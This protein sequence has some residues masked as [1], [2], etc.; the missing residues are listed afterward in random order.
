MN[1]QQPDPA[2]LFEQFQGQA[3]SDPANRSVTGQL[4]H[5]PVPDQS[6]PRVTTIPDSPP[7]PS[8]PVNNDPVS[9]LVALSQSGAIKQLRALK[10]QQAKVADPVNQLVTM[11]QN[12]SLTAMRLNWEDEQY[13]QALDSWEKQKKEF[14]PYPGMGINAY[15]EAPGAPTRKPEKIAQDW[16]K[17]VHYLRGS[18]LGSILNQLETG[19]LTPE[20]EAQI[21]QHIEPQLTPEIRTQ[22]QIARLTRDELQKLNESA[23]VEEQVA[24]EFGRDSL[25]K[26]PF[27]IAEDE[28][29]G[30]NARRG[31]V[32]GRNL[33]KGLTLGYSFAP[34]EERLKSDDP[35]I[36]A[37]ERAKRLFYLQQDS[38]YPVTAFAGN[39]VGAMPHFMAGGALIRGAR[40]GKALLSARAGVPTR[41]VANVIRARG[42]ATTTGGSVAMGAG[43]GAIYD[44][45]TRPEGSEDMSLAEE[46]QARATQVGFGVA[47][48][49]MMELGLLKTG[50]LWQ[51]AKDKR[52]ESQLKKEAKAQGYGGDVN[53][54]LNDLLVMERTDDGR[55]LARPRRKAVSDLPDVELTNEYPGTAQSQR[56]DNASGTKIDGRT[57]PFTEFT[58]TIPERV[59][60]T[61]ETPE[62][63]I[64]VDD[65]TLT[66]GPQS[67]E[68]SGTSK[69][70][71]IIQGSEQPA[72][73][74]QAV[75]TDRATTLKGTTVDVEYELVDADDL[76]TSHL[77]N[78]VVNPDFPAEL[79]PRDRSR[80]ASEAQI[81]SMAADLRPDWLGRSPKASDG[82][83]IIGEDNLVES[84]NGRVSA[85]RQAYA[86]GSGANYRQW[87][88]ENAGQFGLD[89]SLVD[90]MKQPVLVRRRKTAMDNQ[91]RAAFT[92]EANDSDVAR[93]SPSEQARTDASRLDD[94]DIMMFAPDEGG[95]IDTNSNVPFLRRFM[96]RVG[97]TDASAILDSRGRPNQAFV[98][99]V[100]S[101]VFKRAYDDDRLLSLMAETSESELRGESARNILSALTRAAP[102]FARARAM[103]SI[104]AESD[105]IPNMLE[106]VDLVRQSRRDN[107]S[108]SEIISQGSLLE[109]VDPVTEELARFF[110]SNLRSSHRMGEVLKDLGQQLENE[111]A[112]G[113][114]DLFGSAPA[115]KSDFMAATNRNMEARGE[116]A[117]FY[118][119][120]QEPEI[121]EVPGAAESRR[122]EGESAGVGRTETGDAGNGETFETLVENDSHSSVNSE[123]ESKGNTFNIDVETP[124][125][126][127]KIS[128]TKNDDGTITAD[129]QP[130]PK[131]GEYVP[132]THKG[133]ST[134]QANS[135]G[136]LY[137]N[138]INFAIRELS[139]SMN[140]GQAAASSF[141]GGVYGGIQSQQSGEEIGSEQWWLDV[142]KGASAATLGFAA[143]RYNKVIGKDSI[144]SKFSK[145]LG[146]QW[147]KIP[148][149][150][151]GSPEIRRLK[152]QQ[153]LMRQIINRQTGQMGEFLAKNFTP[154]ERSEMADIIENRGYPKHANLVARQAQELDDFITYTADRMKELGMLPPDMET[155]GYLHRYY[156]KHLKLGLDGNL[157]DAFKRAK[158]SLSGSYTIR[159]G[160]NETF[161]PEYLS[162]AVR[163]QMAEYDRI[164]DRISEL[165]GTR[166]DI[167]FD[168]T[169]DELN[170]LRDQLK[171]LQDIQLKEY[172]GIQNGKPHAFIFMPDEVPKVPGLEPS[173]GSNTAPVQPEASDRIWSLR[174]SVGDQPVLWRD[175][176]KAEREKWGEIT[177]AGYRFVRGQAEIAHD[178]SMATMFHKISQRSD[179]VSNRPV[180]MDGEDWIEVPNSKIHK[181]SPMKTYGALAGKYVKPD[182]WRSLKHYNQPLFGRGRAATIYRNLLDRWKLY[183]TVYNPV[184]HFN[185]TVS[186]LQMYYMAGYSAR[187]IV[188]AIN[189]LLK[190]E[191]S[192]LWREARDV[193]MF[194]SDWTSSLLE[195]GEQANSLAELAEVLRNQPDFPDANQVN[196]SVILVNRFKTWL[197]ES[198]AS[199]RNAD[200]KLGS[201]AAVAKAIASPVIDVMNKPI[202]A[203][204]DGAKWLYQKE[205]ELYKMAVFIE[206][207]KKGRSPYEALEAANQFFF[208][209]SDLPDAVR[210][211]K[212]F[213][214]GSP[215]IS[216]TYLALPAI[217][218]NI[219]ER[220]ERVL[221]LAAAFEGLNFASLA[222]DGQLE[223]QGYWDRYEA[224]NIL[225]PSYMKGRTLWGGLNSI[226]VSGFLP[227]LD[228]YKISLANAHAMGSP[229]TGESGR[230]LPLWPSF[231]GFWGPDPIGG[232]PV[233]R[234]PFDILF[235]LDWQGNQLY[236]ENNKWEKSLK[237]AYQAMFPSMPLFPFSWH[238]NKIVEG[239]AGDLNKAQEEGRPANH[240]AEGIVTAANSVSEALGGEQFTGADWKGNQFKTIDALA[241]SVGI[242][243]RQYKP[244]DLY[245]IQNNKIKNKMDEDRRAHKRKMRGDYTK[246]QK[247]KYKEEY[248]TRTDAYK[249]EMEKL[250]EAYNSIA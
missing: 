39:I 37:D 197:I 233:T 132:N 11:S 222:L 178:L 44:A 69:A 4:T 161:K 56:N 226:D 26:N 214:I 189:E 234:I 182:V 154:A 163:G 242:K 250:K 110:D 231:M 121:T 81:R 213:P 140:L 55:L 49:S 50:D 7:T 199:V 143:L 91:Q 232:N 52:F 38:K 172:V 16:Q 104:P 88:K 6:L 105:F 72:V 21:T 171:E 177:D 148:G 73:G 92:K 47:L 64:S 220:P 13:Q 90:G 203:A 100:R 134:E 25:Y 158:Q 97:I 150:G 45:L 230:D 201:G 76:I 238:Q 246:A 15:P 212:D 166:G 204:T 228:T 138:P 131:G 168:Q 125:G 109:P 193:G 221:A 114:A 223:E 153:Q 36:V 247:E 54:Y 118:G 156:A 216:Y 74:S 188:R 167:L 206:E 33:A 146:Q 139:K 14:I 75:K 174:G 59:A 18:E 70:A 130:I 42:A 202:K 86:M 58:D 165:E 229:F 28:R 3:K 101:A 219:I 87:L 116:R 48:G 208:D 200:T 205:D 179:W 126:N 145:Q 61:G 236:N 99:R 89:P 181:N 192:E 207:R 227:G 175:W 71:P 96:K 209:Y 94:D 78:G 239:M 249:A 57:E 173:A 124:A 187:Y 31:N 51:L 245:Q 8:P 194:G 43:E 40:Y 129:G 162:P 83:P 112:R 147:E 180:N 210:K 32:F 107:Q 133:Q 191:N 170:D 24:G 95:N 248:K 135:A 149:L 85:I 196:D 137:S 157:K 63:T 122:T 152:N 102:T 5:R 66:N 117:P 80:V 111:A 224:E 160:T 136:T 225:N 159:R 27:Q 84:G 120:N 68:R 243:L 79:Q 93:L 19:K 142:M 169:S 217:V 218:K 77:N 198:K 123:G 211:I 119:E 108:L 195:G 2:G 98:E 186:N 176:T 235:N 240:L 144:L 241:G 185:N 17:G 106:A 164:R 10:E 60:Q 151:R 53:G 20:Q 41:Q 115:S 127:E 141:G 155:G 46:L 30:Q 113:G 12:G 1:M 29:F 23:L 82:A 237:Y 215:F 190:G 244:K 34:D 184:S 35:A 65:S 128:V 22:L 62:P 183:K 67:V 103:G 9:Q